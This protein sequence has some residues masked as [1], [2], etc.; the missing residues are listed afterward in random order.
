[1]TRTDFIKII[2]LR[3]FW[4][5]DKRRGN[6]TLPNGEHLSSYID[7]LVRGQLQLDSVAPNATGDL[8]SCPGIDPTKAAEKDECGLPVYHLFVAFGEDETCSF[9]EM[10]RRIKSLVNAVIFG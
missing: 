7:E 6:Y 5:I 10:E 9:D 3:S 4:K 2:K 1:M 8:V